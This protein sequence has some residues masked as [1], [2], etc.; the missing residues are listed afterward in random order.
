[1]VGE[2]RLTVP[3]L[4]APALA[5]FFQ[6]QPFVVGELPGLLTPAKKVELVRQFVRAGF[7]TIES[8]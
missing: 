4:L 8:G 7:L 3:A 6:D 1:M 5:R 2:Q